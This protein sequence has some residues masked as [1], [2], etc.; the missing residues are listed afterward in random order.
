M[1]WKKAERPRAETATTAVTTTTAAAT[2]MTTA[3]AATATRW[4][5]QKI[6]ISAIT[7]RDV[8][9]VAREEDFFAELL[10]N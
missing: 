1:T 6:S 5:A 10:S 7:A 3:T 4:Y 8:S 2:G 9:R